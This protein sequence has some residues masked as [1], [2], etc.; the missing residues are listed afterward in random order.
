MIRL[1]YGLSHFGTLIRD[2]YHYVDR[3]PFLAKLEQLN[4][5]YL[6]FLRARRFGKTLFVSM[7]RHYYGREYADKF[8]DLFGQFYVGQNPTP[9][10]NH[11][12]MLFFEFSGIDTETPESTLRDFLENVRS[13]VSYFV[14]VN[15]EFFSTQDRD[16]ILSAAVPNLMLARLFNI[17][18]TSRMAAGSDAQIYLVIDEYD[19]FANE[20]IAF[21]F[22]EFQ[23]IVSRNGFVRKF[24]EQIKTATGEGLIDRLF[25]TGVSPLTLDSLTSGFNI[26]TNYS[27][28]PMFNELMGFTEEEVFEILQGIELSEEQAFPLMQLLREW[29][30]GYLFHPLAEVRVYN[31][32]MVLYFASAYSLSGYPPERMLDINIASDYT[33]VRQL[34]RIDN[35]EERHLALLEEVTTQGLVTGLLTEQFSLAKGFSQDDL[36]SL[37]F[38]MGLLTIKERQL[39]RWRFVMPNLVIQGLYFEYFNQILLERSQLTDDSHHIYDCVVALAQENNIAPLIE[40]VESILRALANRDAMGFDEKYVKAIFASLFYTTQIYTIHSEFEVDRRF[41]DLLLTNRPHVEPNYQFAIELKYLRKTEAS[42]LKSVHQEGRQ[43]LAAYL[44][45]EKLL[46]IPNLKAWLIVIVGTEAQ[47]VEMVAA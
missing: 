29:Y 11:Y 15:N 25:I 5:K 9:L 44:H 22:D 7:L 24:Y 45:H 1:P 26:G 33:K 32:D 6:F 47:V 46:A 23:R 16:F 28:H 41:V 27:T 43:Q 40:V 38:Y 8:D 21:H 30:N 18:R 31:P 13:G 37:L 17:F 2:G 19:H 12:L 35:Q 4:E 14:S 34:F 10:A 39:T 42:R 20:L 36:M 3:T